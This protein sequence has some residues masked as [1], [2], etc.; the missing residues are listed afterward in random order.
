MYGI[1]TVTTKGQHTTPEEVRLLLDIQPGDKIIYEK[2]EPKKKRAS[3]RVIKTKNVIEELAG[4]L[5]PD[6]KIKYVPYSKVREQAGILL[7]KKYE[8]I[9]KRY[10]QQLKKRK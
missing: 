9:G 6:G 7:G 1:T 10:A 2:V 4:S 8:S 3:F 5:N